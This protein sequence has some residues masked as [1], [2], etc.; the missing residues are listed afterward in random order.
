MR[1]FESDGGPSVV[2]VT[3]SGGGR[4]LNFN[5]VAILLIDRSRYYI[6]LPS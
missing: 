5:G 2:G 6:S 4:L 3:V 1:E